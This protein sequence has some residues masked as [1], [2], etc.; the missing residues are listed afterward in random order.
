MTAEGEAIR[1]GERGGD[2]R[3]L[4]ERLGSGK[5][6]ADPGLVKAR[7]GPENGFGPNGGALRA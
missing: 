3:L 1:L 5:A 4:T 2:L 6:L 7:R